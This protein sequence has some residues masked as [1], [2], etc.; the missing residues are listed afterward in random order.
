MTALDRLIALAGLRGTL[1][2]RCQLQGAWT[3]DHPP[4][5]A[6]QASYHL[7]LEGEC[8]LELAGGQRQRLRAGDILLL[9][10][11]SAHALHGV[12]PGAAPGQALASDNGGLPVIRGGDGGAALDMLCGSFHYQPEASLLAALPDQLLVSFSEDNASANAALPALVA[13]LRSEAEGARDGAQTLVNTLSNALFTL[14]LR[15]YLA[16]ESQPNGALAVLTDRRIG[17]VWAAVLADLAYDWSVDELASRAAMSRATFSRAFD[18]L[19]GVSPGT[20]LLRL[21]MERAR[22]LL[23]NSSLDLTSIALEVGYQSQAAFTRAFRQVYGDAPGRF[24]RT[25]AQ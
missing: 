10:R 5:P 6:G 16:A 25:V 12:T 8:W 13:L 17:P 2:L 9:P 22:D 24:R 21:R 18:R 15:A 4:T 14:L 11:G 3:M 23:R 19:S 1:D 20:M 7:L